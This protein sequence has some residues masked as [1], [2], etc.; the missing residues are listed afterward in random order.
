MLKII[1][2]KR[3]EMTEDE[4]GL[5]QKICRSYDRPNFKGEELFKNLFE[6]DKNGIIIFLKPPSER[7][8]SMEVIIFILN[9]MTQQHL[10]NI[11]N[12]VN[13]LCKELREKYD[14]KLEK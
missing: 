9:L 11:H 7:Q 13:E 8:C 2:N 14:K 1:D 4:W 10:R 12:Q 6:T 3:I 5:Y